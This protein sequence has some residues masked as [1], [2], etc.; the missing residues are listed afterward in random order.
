MLIKGSSSKETTAAE[1]EDLFK[2]KTLLVA[3][4]WPLIHRAADLGIPIHATDLWGA[5]MGKL[6]GSG[7]SPPFDQ[8]KARK[9]EWKMSQAAVDQLQAEIDRVSKGERPPKEPLVFAMREKWAFAP[10]EYPKRHEDRLLISYDG[11]NPWVKEH[12]QKVLNLP[13]GTKEVTYALGREGVKQLGMNQ[14]IAAQVF[15]LVGNGAATVT[16]TD[17]RFPIP[18]RVVLDRVGLNHAT[19]NTGIVRTD[20]TIDHD[21]LEQLKSYA[22]GKKYLTVHDLGDYLWDRF[23][24]Q[25][26]GVLPLGERLRRLLGNLLFSRGELGPFFAAARE[27][28]DGQ[29]VVTL[30]RIEKLYAHEVWDEIR[31]MRAAAIVDANDPVHAQEMAGARSTLA[32]WAKA[33][34]SSGDAS[35]I[36]KY[37]ADLLIGKDEEERAFLRDGQGL[38]PT[39][40]IALKTLWPFGRSSML[41]LCP[42]CRNSIP[43]K[44]LPSA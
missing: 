26:N 12:L 27:K 22:R 25:Q 31:A 13:A 7:Y 11:P 8:A 35:D 40:G 20:G 1:K 14:D 2:D 23:K 3:D 15:G 17:Q 33:H 6:N 21:R 28:R 41:A 24:E 10:G 32:A 39:V 43:S 4:Q 42:A 38:A 19:S 34:P 9:T 30:D 5:T 16:T 36:A 37:A 18:V 44:T 29:W